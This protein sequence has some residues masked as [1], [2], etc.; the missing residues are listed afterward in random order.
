MFFYR[1]LSLESYSLSAGGSF[2]GIWI[3]GI[4]TLKPLVVKMSVVC[5]GEVVLPDQIKNSNNNS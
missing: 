1:E 2:S 5:P 3:S 4:V